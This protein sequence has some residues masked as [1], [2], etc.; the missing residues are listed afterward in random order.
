MKATLKKIGPQF[1][2]R[3]GKE[4]KEKTNINKQATALYPSAGRL[5]IQGRLSVSYS[6]I[7]CLIFTILLVNMVMQALESRY[8]VNA[9]VLYG[10]LEEKFGKGQF[11]VTVGCPYHS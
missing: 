8:T 10:Y 11:S 1:K 2:G 4:K 5:C 3:G 9:D 6:H 7:H